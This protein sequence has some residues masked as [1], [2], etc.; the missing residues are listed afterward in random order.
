ML[1]PA[2]A[3]A[4]TGRY[5][6]LGDSY[7]SG[8]GTREYI[9]DG[10]TCQRS[11]H[12]YPSLLAAQRGYRL[13]FRGRN[14]VA[15]S[16]G[17]PGSTTIDAHRTGRVVTFANDEGPSA[18]LEGFRII[19]GDTRQSAGSEGGG[20]FVN[21]AAPTIRGNIIEG[22]LACNG[23]GIA[24]AFGSPAVVDNQI[25][26]NHRVGCSGGTGGGG[27]LLRGAGQARLEGN[28]ITA[29]STG[30]AGGGVSMFAAGTPQIVDNVITANTAWSDGGG[31]R[32]VNVSDAIITQNL[33]SDNV[34]GQKGGGIAWLVPSGGIGPR[35]TNNTIVANTAPDGAAI[36][37]DGFQDGARLTNNVIVAAS[38]TAMVCGTTYGKGTPTFSANDI[39]SASGRPFSGACTDPIGSDGNISADPKVPASAVPVPRPG[40]P[41]IDAGD[42]AADVG[43]FDLAGNPRVVYGNGDGTPR[44]DIGAYELQQPTPELSV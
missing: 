9:D 1:A 40:S 36:Y 21:G 14:C 27:V 7:S 25:R 6:A 30:A 42:P 33:V 39:W 18:V 15:R 31:L 38:G 29:N 19:G 43:S 12:A 20:I 28:T 4:G 23:N 22:N 24:V 35:L 26:D 3:Q 44:I 11:V 32:L 13:D 10:T 16:T 17:G 37:A 8:T 2:P 34:A 41:L 5:V